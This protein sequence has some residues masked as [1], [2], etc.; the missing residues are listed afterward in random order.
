MEFLPFQDL[1]NVGTLICFR[2]GQ[3]DAEV[4]ARE[5]FPVL[6][7]ADLV[8]LPNWQAYVTTLVNGQHAEPFNIQTVSVD[9]APD[10]ARASRVVAQAR[11]RYARAR[12]D[13]EADVA[14]SFGRT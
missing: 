5:M 13:A 2:V 1:G 6:T 8:G 10:A 11:E 12:A 14:A 4:L 3:A 9:G 7:R